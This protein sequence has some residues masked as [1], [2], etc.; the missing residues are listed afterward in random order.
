M[1]RIRSC[2]ILLAIWSVALVSCKGTKDVAGSRH[3]AKIS[4]NELVSKVES[5]EF[6]LDQIEVKMNVAFKTDKLSDSFKMYARMKK[7]S[8][9]WL[10]ATYYK[11]E[12]ARILMT[13]DSVHL[14]DKRNKKYYVG[15]FRVI[16]ESFNTEFNFF[17]LQDLILGNAHS[18]L[19]TSKMKLQNHKNFYLLN[20]TKKYKKVQDIRV[21]QL[22]DDFAK[23]QKEDEMIYPKAFVLHYHLYVHPEKFKVDRLMVRDGRNNKSIFIKYDD[24]KEVGG[25]LLPHELLY[26]IVTNEIFKVNVT[27]MRVEEKEELSFPFKVTDKYE[28]IVY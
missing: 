5:G 23:K 24:Y 18:T 4:M 11:V 3:L 2:S 28:R 12:V 21:P 16:N 10:S 27:Y 6:D 26:N 19:S 9:I 22:R 25:K 14:L 17:T 7:D 1:R 20:T 15:D 13:P 8:V